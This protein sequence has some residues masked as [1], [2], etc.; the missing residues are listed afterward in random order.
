MK[1]MTWGSQGPAASSLR[2]PFFDN[3][4]ENAPA[5]GGLKLWSA[6]AAVVLSIICSLVTP[7]NTHSVRLRYCGSSVRAAGG[8]KQFGARSLGFQNSGSLK[9]AAQERSTKQTKP[10]LPL[11]ATSYPRLPSTSTSASAEIDGG[12]ALRASAI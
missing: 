4:K 10:F 6:T 7:A 8:L 2:Y 5:S 1:N 3:M 11:T 12:A 9:P